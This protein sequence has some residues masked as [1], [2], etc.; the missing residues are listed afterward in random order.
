MLPFAQVPCG[1]TDRKILGAVKTTEIQKLVSFT[2][3][4]VAEGVDEKH[5]GWHTAPWSTTIIRVAFQPEVHDNAHNIFEMFLIHFVDA[6]MLLW[7]TA[8]NRQ[9]FELILLFELIWLFV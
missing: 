8:K 3:H 1:C 4:V 9:A 6:L 7:S 5:D 2:I